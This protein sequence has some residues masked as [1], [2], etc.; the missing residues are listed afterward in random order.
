VPAARRKYLAL[1]LTAEK[2]WSDSWYAQFSYTWAH[3]YGNTEGL[4]D[5]DINQADTGTTV[6]FDY[7]E[8]MI[9][10]YG[11]LPNDRRHTLKAL[12]GWHASR[13]VTLA[14]NFRFQTGRPRICLGVNPVDSSLAPWG[15]NYGNPYLYC[16]GAV[17]PRGSLGFQP[18]EW[19][20]DLGATYVPHALTRLSIQAKVY[21]V[22]NRHTVENTL[23]LSVSHANVPVEDY[24]VPTDYQPPR[25]FSLTAEYKFG[26]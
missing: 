8:I 25:A 24:R 23:P 20:L 11:N 3:N 1:D 12:G 10:T 5:S 15:L 7:K 13:E 17:S 16:N 21:N 19:N 22:F 4:V 9:G 2:T 18:S 26:K 6:N 14:A